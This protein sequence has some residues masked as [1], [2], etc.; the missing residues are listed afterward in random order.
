MKFLRYL[1]FA[2]LICLPTGAFSQSDAQEASERLE[3]LAGSWAG[4]YERMPMVVWNR[5]PTL[6]VVSAMACSTATPGGAVLSGAVV[7]ARSRTGIRPVHG[8]TPT[9]L[10]RPQTLQ[11]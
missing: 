6:Q 7:S 8:N 2:L 10:Y 9:P 5:T 1:L 11:S 3:T 4:A